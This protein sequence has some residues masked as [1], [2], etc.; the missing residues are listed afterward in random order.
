MQQI[1]I[2]GGHAQALQTALD[3]A[4]NIVRGEMPPTGQQIVAAF[5]TQENLVA[6]G[7][8]LEE[9]ANQPLAVA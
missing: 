6:V 4:A 9:L 7:P 2:D 8:V 1:H 5:G 3:A